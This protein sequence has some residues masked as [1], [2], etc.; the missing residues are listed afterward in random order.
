[1]DKQFDLHE[2]TIGHET[3]AE[4]PWSSGDAFHHDIELQPV[5]FSAKAIQ[6]GRH[7]VSIGRMEH[8]DVHASRVGWWGEVMEMY[9][10][11]AENR[12]TEASPHTYELTSFEHTI[13]APTAEG[14]S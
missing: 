7:P 10:R 3:A 12:I 11:L 14:T 9:F 1:M 2:E 5:S 13:L 6:H 8:P 4:E